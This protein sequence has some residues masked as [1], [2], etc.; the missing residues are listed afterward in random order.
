MSI[1]KQYKAF[2]IRFRKTDK[3]EAAIL[4]VLEDLNLDI[5]KSINQ[6]IVDA[7]E[8]YIAH[9]DDKE[10][11]GPTADAG[12]QR[13]I[14]R[15]EF[16]EAIMKMNNDLEDAKEEIKN[17]LYEEMLKLIIGGSFMNVNAVLPQTNNIANEKT[18]V[19]TEKQT[20]NE[21][22]DESLIDDVMKWS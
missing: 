19:E 13:Y 9:F 11:I 15:V 8:Y 14:S 7:V 20:Q 21:E 17:Q 2:S 10:L 5:H 16:N 6:F 18:N 3:R 12:K 4:R 1:P 22:E